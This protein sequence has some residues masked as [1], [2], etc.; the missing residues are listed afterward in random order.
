MLKER[1]KALNLMK[2]LAAI[3][4]AYFYHYRNDFA[5]NMGKNFPYENLSGIVY[6]GVSWWSV[7]GW[8]LTDLFFILSGM[9]FITAYGKKIAEGKM[10]F[11]NFINNRIKRL[12]PMMMISTIAMTIMEYMHYFCRGGWW[13]SEANIWNVFI[14]IIGMPTGWFNMG[15]II[16][17][18]I[19]YIS[20][21]FQ[22]Y[23]IAYIFVRIISKYRCSQYILFIPIVFNLSIEYSG[24]VN[25]NFLLVNMFSTR[26][27]KAFFIGIILMVVLEKY[28]RLIESYRKG[29]LACAYTILL[30]IY[31]L[32]KEFGDAIFGNLLYVLVFIVYPNV[33][34]IVLYSDIWNRFSCLGIFQFLGKVSF[35]MYLWN[36]PIQLGTILISS[37]IAYEFPYERS[38]F[39]I[40]HMVISIAISSWIYYFI[41]IPIQK[42]I[43]GI[44]KDKFINR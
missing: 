18:P 36:L 6:G 19:W 28:S 1:M 8:M 31:A 4:I 11:G 30:L 5:L 14:S 37:W 15:Y 20:I 34:F 10:S 22:C 40:I 39:L 24:I 2:A 44:M 42:K 25:T 21:L 23:I 3:I 9:T 43:N 16:N 41:E 7:N 13:L 33:I 26:G 38:Y 12:F 17:M 35:E 29:L 27:I 32:Y